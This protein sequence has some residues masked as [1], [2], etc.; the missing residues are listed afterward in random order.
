MQLLAGCGIERRGWGVRDDGSEVP[1]RAT[2]QND[3]GCLQQRYGTNQIVGIATVCTKD[4]GK[5]RS[6]DAGVDGDG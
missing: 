1:S 4:D 5:G 3:Q 2:H 6:D